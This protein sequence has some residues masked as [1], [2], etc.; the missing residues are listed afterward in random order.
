MAFLSIHTGGFLVKLELCPPRC[1]TL[2]TQ[3]ENDYARAWIRAAAGGSAL[4]KEMRSEVEDAV[5]E[6]A[7][8]H[9]VAAEAFKED[10]GGANEGE[11]ASNA[12]RC[13]E[14]QRYM[15]FT[16]PSPGGRLIHCR[17]LISFKG[18]ARGRRV[19]LIP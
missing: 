19:L 10:C 5:W 8:R 18:E 1:L 6:A 11:S 4:L 16:M 7:V 3:R 13:T 17:R 15:Y 14:Q 9:A 12:S 2:R